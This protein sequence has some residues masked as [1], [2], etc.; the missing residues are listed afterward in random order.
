MKK[1]ILKS[2]S[3]ILA[4][5]LCITATVPSF[6][7][8]ETELNRNCPRIYIPGF[9]TSL[10]YADVNDP[11]SEV[12]WPPSQDAILAAVEK[13]L[14][15]IA[16]LAI[17][18]NFDRFGTNLSAV[19]DELFEPS[20]LGYD[21]EPKEG[22]GII[23]NY[24]EPEKIGVD[25]EVTFDYDWRV[26]PIVTARELD[27]F[28]D[29]VLECS[30]CDEVVLECHSLG[31]IITLS[32]L[33][34][35]GTQ[36][37]RS[38]LF[39]STAIYGETYTG[40]LLTG[41]IDISDDAVS[42]YMEYAFD[43]LGLD[44]FFSL[45]F[46]A[47]TDAGIIDLVCRNADR[48]VDEIYD[49]AMLSVL[50]LFANWLTIWAMV[51]DELVDDAEHFVFD[52]MYKNAGI[53][54]S[55]LK[56][57]VD[58]YNTTVRNYK[59]E[60]LKTVNAQANL[61]VVSRHGYSSFPLTPSWD[62]MSD[63]VIDT[64]YNSFGA[65]VAK[66]GET[67]DI[68]MNEYVS[69]DK[70]IDASTCLFPKQTWFIEDIGHNE[71]PSCFDEFVDTLLYYDGQA[72]VDTFDCYPRFM[73]FDQENGCLTYDEPNKVLSWYNKIFA[74]IQELLKAIFKAFN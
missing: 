74:A 54:Y 49:E 70:T 65:T 3:L 59:T 32:Y 68:E 8:N 21:G 29:Y 66:Y 2:I 38:V 60:T 53:D 27:K 36:K 52:E 1:I 19:L 46:G 18:K 14:L 67:L 31:G 26:D 20:C 61:Y 28:I 44:N 48:L 35:Y 15:P 9:M 51:P 40:E 69:P 37:V 73:T 33:K 10:I 23:F 30:G 13:A 7:Q 17:T 41:N 57:K 24:P 62:N 11:N 64:K 45:L 6:A 34:L 71:M 55:G 5:V 63:G 12:I 42:C 4:L 39:N 47:L 16:D 56:A 43:S 50:R 58:N 22:T 25:A 72:T